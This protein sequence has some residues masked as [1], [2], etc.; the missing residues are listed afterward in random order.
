ME[1]M[2]AKTTGNGLRNGVVTLIEIGVK[3]EA[4]GGGGNA[5]Q[6]VP[7]CKWLKE[8]VRDKL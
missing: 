2:G 3:I 8:K 1:Q 4:Q 7:S 6:Q 5:T